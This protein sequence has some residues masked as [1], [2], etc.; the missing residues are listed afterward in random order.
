MYS[1]GAIFHFDVHSMKQGALI[2]NLINHY[3]QQYHS[4]PV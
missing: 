4:S 1:I 2:A 3:L